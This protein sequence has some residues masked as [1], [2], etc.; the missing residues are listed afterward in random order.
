MNEINARHL[1]NGVRMI[2]PAATYID[3]TVEIAADVTIY[4]NAVL[5]GA[6]KIEAGAYIGPGAHLKNVYVGPNAKIHSYSVLTDAKVGADTD[7]GPFAYLR[8]NAE[9][10]ERCRIGSFVEIKK[11]RV[12]DDTNAAHLAYIGDAAVGRN[13][14]IGCGVITANYDGKTKS[15]TVIGDNAFIG[16]NANLIAPVEVGEWGYI[17]AGSTVN[18]DIP[19]DALAI[20][21]ARQVV[22]PDWDKNPYKAKHAGN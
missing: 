18:E 19:A 8:G 12:G 10:G 2:D 17:A 9:V 21:R 7:I 14:N 15:R 11:S 6:C 1:Q 4:P 13:V 5:E 20:A 16:S 3:E 22:K